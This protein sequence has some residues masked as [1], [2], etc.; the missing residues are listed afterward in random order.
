MIGRVHYFEY[1]RIESAFQM[2]LKYIRSKTYFEIYSF[3]LHR[4]SWIILHAND[5]L[6]IAQ[7]LRAILTN[8]LLVSR[9]WLL[10]PSPK[11]SWKK[12]Q[13]RKN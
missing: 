11:G 12:S 7:K 2:K 8:V 10:F 1:S 6:V 3:Y 4:I 9:I 13:N 5:K